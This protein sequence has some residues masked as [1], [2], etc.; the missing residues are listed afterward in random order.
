M[1][2]Q[3]NQLGHPCLYYESFEEQL[4]DQLTLVLDTLLSKD[5]L[6]RVFYATIRRRVLRARRRAQREALRQ[7]TIIE[8]S[9]DIPVIQ[10]A[11]GAGAEPSPRTST[12][13]SEIMNLTGIIDLTGID[14][15]DNIF[16]L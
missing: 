3:A 16:N 4:D 13:T 1:E 5:I 7:N 14:F 10:E 8:P 2:D 9:P 11:Y 12:P 15:D 6:I